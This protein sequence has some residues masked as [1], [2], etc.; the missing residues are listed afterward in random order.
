M[1]LQDQKIDPQLVEWIRSNC[2]LQEAAVNLREIRQTG[3]Q[4]LVDFDAELERILQ[5]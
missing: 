1:R 4:R 5:G 2:D 3:G